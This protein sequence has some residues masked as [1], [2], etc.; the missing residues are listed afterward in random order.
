[1]SN[2]T[3]FL[4]ISCKHNLVITQGAVCVFKKVLEIT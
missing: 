3:T 1:M 2:L 4:M